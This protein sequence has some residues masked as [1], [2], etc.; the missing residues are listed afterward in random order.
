MRGEEFPGQRNGRPDKDRVRN[1]EH[2]SVDTAICSVNSTEAKVEREAFVLDIIFKLFLVRLF[3]EIA[4]FEVEYLADC[5]CAA[6]LKLV[7][8]PRSPESSG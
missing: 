5:D 4:A 6:G 1:A 7:P 2:S 3:Q 8:G